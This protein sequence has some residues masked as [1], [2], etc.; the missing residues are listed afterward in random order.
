MDRFTLPTFSRLLAIVLDRATHPSSPVHG[1]AHWRAVGHT[2]LE[3]APR[4]DRADALLGLLFGLLHDSQRLN[5]G[6]DPDHGPRAARLARDLHTE[7]L[8]PLDSA[9]LVT[10]IDAIDRHTVGRRS[11]HPTIALCWDADRLNLWRIGIRPD[12]AF[13]STAAAREPAVIYAHRSLPGERVPWDELF[14][15]C[16]ALGGER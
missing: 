6:G 1:E 7:G 2:A 13:L 15:R 8:L 14:Q 12:A 10:L 9:D 3:L 5:D 11:D 4:V 16:L